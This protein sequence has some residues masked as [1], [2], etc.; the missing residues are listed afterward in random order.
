MCTASFAR[1]EDELTQTVLRPKA[2]RISHQIARPL[3]APENM[4]LRTLVKISAPSAFLFE[5]A[6]MG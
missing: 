1:A 3:T 6:K 5:A 2:S 4:T